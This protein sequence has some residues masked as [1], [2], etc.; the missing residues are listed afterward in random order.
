MFILS[1]TTFSQY[2]RPI[3]SLNC[4][5]ETGFLQFWLNT[6]FSTYL[7]QLRSSFYTSGQI[8]WFTTVL[9]YISC[10]NHTAFVLK[11]PRELNVC[12][13]CY[14][15]LHSHVKRTTIYIIP[16]HSTWSGCFILFFFQI[17][18]G[19]MLITVLL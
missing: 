1:L 18:A 13:V 19:D 8:K 14:G 10:I 16:Y 7:L 3:W 6:E 4:T 11:S 12:W 2:D 15:Y 9:Y 17:R 5:D